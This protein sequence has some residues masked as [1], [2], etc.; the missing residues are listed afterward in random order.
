MKYIVKE[1]IKLLDFLYKNISKSKNTIKK[2][3]KDN[4][5]VN[6]IK[7]SK[8][9]YLLKENDIV[10]IKSKINN[11]D[12]LYEDKNIIVIN[13]P[14]GLLT[15]G[16]TNEKEKTA[17]H[18]VGEYLK[19]KNK[20]SKVFV[21]HR[22]DKETSGI[23]IFA[24]DNK[25]KKMYQENWND[26]VKTRGYIAIVEGKTKDKVTIKT[27]LVENKSGYVYSSKNGKLAVTEYQ[28]IKENDKYTMLDIKIKTGR[29]NQI[30]VHLS[31]MNNPIIGDKKYKSNDNPINRLGLCA[32]KLELINPI[33]NKNM[34]FVIKIPSSFDSIF[35]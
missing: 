19:T 30:R 6:N 10:E 2:I 32:N 21:I 3:L 34:I 27:N 23:V 24:K 29:K 33:N 7:I 4:T 22:L 31:E 9:D 11:I 20:N 1:K 5:Y 17:Y 8:F 15:V 25:T 12:I 16:T 18:L 28:K 14:S 13:K 35:R 26:L